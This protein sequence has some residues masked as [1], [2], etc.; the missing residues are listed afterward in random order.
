MNTG[1][2]VPDEL[3][4]D[5]VRVLVSILLLFEAEALA[6]DFLLSTLED[7][8]GGMHIEEEKPSLRENSELI[9]IRGVELGLDKLL[10]LAGQLGLG[11]DELLVFLDIEDSD[12]KV[13]H[14]AHKKQELAAAGERKADDLDGG[15]DGELSN[16][17]LVWQLVDVAL[18]VESV[19][20]GG[21]EVGVVV[22]GCHA[23]TVALGP[24]VSKGVTYQM[25]SRLLVWVFQSTM[26]A[27]EIWTAVSSSTTVKS[28]PL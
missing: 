5:Q 11:H 9:L 3:G 26:A 24:G 13:G 16:K 28:S 15:V 12:L 20:S 21:Q 2:G 10:G 7:V 17:L 1:V 22:A 18:G 25:Y 27:P 6:Q 23:V 14:A 8:V 4:E 19:L